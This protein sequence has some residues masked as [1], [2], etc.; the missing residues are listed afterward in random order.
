VLRETLSG[1][2]STIIVPNFSWAEDQEAIADRV[3][4]AVPQ[5]AK[6]GYED[7]DR[8]Y[9]LTRAGLDQPPRQPWSEATEAATQRVAA[10]L[11]AVLRSP[12]RRA[13]NVFL[14]A[15][16]LDT[17]RRREIVGRHLPT[18]PHAG[19]D[20][21]LCLLDCVPPTHESPAVLYARG[22]RLLLSPH[23]VSYDPRHGVN[24]DAG[25]GFDLP[26]WRQAHRPVEHGLVTAEVR[27]IH[28]LPDQPGAVGYQLARLREIEALPALWLDMRAL[29]T[30]RLS[31]Y[32]ATVAAALS[33]DGARTASVTDLLDRQVAAQLM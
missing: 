30:D 17:P 8:L 21:R 24:Y 5:V 16:G 18:V 12:A 33:T 1:P 7:V 25:Y 29:A 3:I 31:G 10:E 15:S 23:G 4:G 14:L 19:D 2:A 11:L 22:V 26:V 27:H 6:A 20:R 13:P 28:A 32:C 9:R